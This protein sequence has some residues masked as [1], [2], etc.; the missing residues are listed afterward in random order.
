MVP[1]PRN[2]DIVGESQVASWYESYQKKRIESGKP[3]HTG[4]LRL[5]LCG[6]GGI[7]YVLSNETL[8]SKRTNR[9]SRKAQDVLRFIYDYENQRPVFWIHAGNV[10][11]FE[12]D[13]RKLGSLAKIPGHRDDDTKQNIGLIV[14]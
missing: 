7:G 8:C 3:E 4:H 1:F 10:T 12:A 11:Q 6:L 2:E 14:K 5:A 9:K 13:C